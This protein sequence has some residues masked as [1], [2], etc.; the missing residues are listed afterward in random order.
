MSDTQVCCVKLTYESPTDDLEKLLNINSDGTINVKC[1]LLSLRKLL[2][3]NIRIID[4][5]LEKA[6]DI[7]D[8]IPGDF[9][10]FEI[11]INSR[12]IE[13]LRNENILVNHY[14]TGETSDEEIDPD[15]NG[16]FSDDQDSS[17]EENHDDNLQ[18]LRNLTKNDPELD[19]TT[20]C[21]NSDD[22]ID[23][24]AS[25]IDEKYGNEFSISD[26][27][28]TDESRM[29]GDSK[30]KNLIISKYRELIGRGYRNSNVS[31]DELSD[32]E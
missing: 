8:I 26:E 2:N 7:K 21:Y 20:V 30:N 6:D 24:I 18:L 11:N 31:E 29:I 5:L 15:V 3:E 32:I 9:G 12:E 27:D 19:E 1:T 23:E 10:F 14:E 17:N 28:E 16:L 25:I 13:S 22:D 4:V